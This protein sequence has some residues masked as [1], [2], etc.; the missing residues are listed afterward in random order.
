MGCPAVRAFCARWLNGLAWSAAAR[1]PTLPTVNMLQAKCSLSRLVN[2]VESGAEAE[3][4]IAR[5][6][7]AADAGRHAQLAAKV[8]IV[9]G[10]FIAKFAKALRSQRERF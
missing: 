7:R 1:V 8:L 10:K 3:I 9:S 4:V 5:N 6:G 2:P